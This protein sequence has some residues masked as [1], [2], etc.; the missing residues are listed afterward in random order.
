[1]G[2]RSAVTTEDGLPG[3]AG[4]PVLLVAHGS[5][6]PAAAATVRALA[7]LVA[8]GSGRPVRV[9]FLDHGPPDPATVLTTVATSGY[10]GAVVVPL[11]FTAAYHRRVDLP[12][13]LAPVRERFPTLAVRITDVL[14]PAGRTAPVPEPLLAGLV[15]RLREARPTGRSSG[16]E[17]DAVVLAAAGTT[18]PAAQAT[19]EKVAAALA[20]RLGVPCRAGFASAAAPT[21]EAA[22]RSLRAAGARRV[23]VAGYFL[24]P[25][26]LHDR[27]VAGARAAGAGP[28]AAPLGAL[29]EMA[30]LVLARVG[31]DRTALHTAVRPGSAAPG[32]TAG[33]FWEIRMNARGDGSRR[34]A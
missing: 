14:G 27:A 20:V 25:G 7:R 28:V 33:R 26:L 16:R 19:V 18:D 30:E 23:A 4:E 1:M 2:T 15:R 10:R 34:G 17:W 3:R 24:A 5:R 21:P 22:V 6:R 9:A 29:P 8:A 31:R 13:V 12:A 32:R 11:L